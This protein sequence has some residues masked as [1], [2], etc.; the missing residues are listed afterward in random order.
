[1]DLKFDLEL[2]EETVGKRCDEVA[3]KIEDDDTLLIVG[4]TLVDIADK[5]ELKILSEAL[6]AAAGRIFMAYDRRKRKK[7]IAV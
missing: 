1:L 7:E 4:R 2:F 5:E 6:Y 3:S